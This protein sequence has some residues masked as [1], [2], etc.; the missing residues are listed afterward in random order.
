MRTG[1][2][3]APA[4][5]LNFGL[6]RRVELVLEAANYYALT[7]ST[8]GPRDNLLDT[9]LTAKIV[10]REGCLQEHA[11][12]SVATE[13]GLLLPQ[14]GGESGLGATASG[15]VSQCFGKTFTIHYNGAANLTRALNLDLFGSAILEGPKTWAIRPVAEFYVEREFN[16]GTTYSALL[17]VIWPCRENLDLDFAVRVA[18]ST[19]AEVDLLGTTLG[20]TFETPVYLV[21]LGFTWRL[22]LFEK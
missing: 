11:G 9:Q 15:I 20:D 7:S 8:P 6:A 13:L 1:K 22:A 19:D 4:V 12:L 21:R 5:V 10:L 17:G 14:T 16:V 18:T 2:L 3:V